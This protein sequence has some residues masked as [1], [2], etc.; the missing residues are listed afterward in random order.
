MLIVGIDSGTNKPLSVAKPP[1]TTC[2]KVI[3]DCLPRV[4]LY[5]TDISIDNSCLIGRDSRGQ[6]EA[7]L[8]VS[9]TV[10]LMS[11]QEI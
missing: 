2:S 8:E 3:P 11:T 7:F 9:C 10:D 5:L 4:D 6:Y 1:K